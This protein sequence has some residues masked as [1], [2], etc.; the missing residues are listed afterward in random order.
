MLKESTG[1]RVGQVRVVFSLPPSSG[2]PIPPERLA[3]VEWFSKFASPESNH[4]MHKLKRS[5]QG[6][7]HIASIIPVSSIRRSVHLFP[8]FGPTVPKDWTA[9]NV[10]EKCGTFYLNPFVDRNMYFIS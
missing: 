6:G 9:E 7:D 5:S 8:K 3:Y 1:Y 2:T 4:G 10:L